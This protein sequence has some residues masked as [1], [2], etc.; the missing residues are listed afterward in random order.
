MK[1]LVTGATGFLGRR[2]VAKLL[3]RANSTV[4]VLIRRASADKMDDLRIRLDA[5]ES[6]LIPVWGDITKDG[7]IDR[8][9]VERLSGEIDHVFHL[10]A[11]YDM[12]MS[13]ATA[14][15]FNVK[16]TANVLALAGALANANKTKPRFHYMSSVAVAGADHVGRF[17]DEMFDVGQRLTHPYYRT[18]FQAEAV[19]REHARVP[20]RIYRPG[21]VVGDSQTGQIDK[22]DG[23]YY[24]FPA[25]KALRDRLPKWLPLL[26]IEGG[27]MPIAPVDYVIDA[28]VHIAHK[29]EG[30]GKAYL[31]IQDNPP[32]AGEMTKIFVRAAHGPDV[33]H[34]LPSQQW[35]GAL[36]TQIKQIGAQLPAADWLAKRAAQS[37]GVPLAILGYIN[38]RAVFD[39]VNTRAALAGSS[40]SC[41][42]LSEYAETLW[43]Y[44]E[45]H[46]D[47]DV[48]VS[49]S[50]VR[51]A[52]GRV[53]V[54]TGGS[55]GIGFATAKKL[56]AAGATVC[57]VARNPDKL[58]EAR[59]IIATIGTAYAYSCDLSD[60]AAIDACTDAI[61]AEHHH[62]DILINNA[63]HSI[64]RAVFESL[65]RFHDYERTMQLNY[66]GALRMIFNFLPTMAKRRTG[67]ILNVSSI[68]V[69]TNAPRFSAYVASKSALDAFSRCLSPE[70]ASRNIDLTAVYMPLVRTPM[71]APTKLYD[72]VPALTP[73]QAADMIANAIVDRPKSVASPLGTFAQVSYAMWPRFNDFVLH[74]AFHMFPSSKV[75]RTKSGPAENS[76]KLNVPARLLAAILPGPYW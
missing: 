62:V 45:M 14:D 65:N 2:L 21:M 49:A 30:N 63:G 71:I 42:P 44:W 61:L 54:I 8:A 29:R 57:L 13:D 39:D 10:A 35:S 52:S 23:P 59:S 36:E 66:F 51:R 22:I 73:E 24:F 7:V 56:A 17:S 33:I 43:R 34:N 20:W 64:R 75:A 69:L 37:L 41:P 9:A 60:I 19:V 15:L 38:N 74:K 46:L 72:Y 27:Q 5:D 25:I 50:L 32:T 16:G 4:Y 55:S 11:V 28:T 53:V 47:C 12:D 58:E 31:L 40:I 67:H 26:G 18:K 70:V 68:G 48:D 1:Y 76:E 6:R 3:A